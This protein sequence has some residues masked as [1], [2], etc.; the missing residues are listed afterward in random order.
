MISNRK[1][2]IV[3]VLLCLWVLL[4]AIAGAA[5]NESPMLK[6]RVLRGELPPV[7]ERLPK[8][9]VVIEP[10]SE[11]GQYGGTL[12]MALTGRHYVFQ[13]MLGG[14]ISDQ[15][16]YTW[17][18]DASEM[19]PNW[20]SETTISED[21]KVFTVYLRE[22]IKWSDGVPVTV[23][24][25]LFGYQDV[26]FNPELTPV[27]PTWLRGVEFKKIS[28]YVLE[29]HLPAPSPQFRRYFAGS[30]ITAANDT[31]IAKHYYERFH[32][33]YVD[34]NELA[35]AMK[36]EGIDTWQELFEAKVQNDNPEKPVL[37]MWKVV[38]V[39]TD[40]VIAERNPYYWKVD[41]EG[42][43]LPYI[44]RLQM[45]IVNSD[46]V[47]TMRAMAGEYDF[48]IF[49]ISL[50]DYPTLVSGE[51]RGGYRTFLWEGVEADL[52][53][54]VNQTYEEDTVIG[55]LLRKAEFKQALSYAIDR[56]EINELV[57]MGTGK[58]I[59]LS[60]LEG[61]SI[62]KPDYPN[63]HSEYNPS[64]AK[65]LLD[66]LGLIDRDGDGWRDRPDGQMLRLDLLATSGWDSHIQ[67]GE[68]M[69]SYWDSI[70]I[71]T[72]LEVYSFERRDQLENANRF[73][74]SI[75]KISNMVYPT[76]LGTAVH[77]LFCEGSFA[78]LWT[79][80]IAT[81][82][83]QGKEPSA[84]YLAANDVFQ[85]I[86]KEIDP[87]R[88]DKLARDFWEIYYRNLWTIGVVQ[89]VPRPIVVHNRLKNVP[90]RVVNSWDPLKT[91]SNADHAMWYIAD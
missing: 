84:D 56:D 20:V 91:P 55:D 73:Q 87:G 69:K 40:R 10:Y 30:F 41:T 16:P 58:P 35:A 43:Q 45:D 63:M 88:R 66:E 8:E 44:D 65:A 27:A 54:N 7:T 32:P 38:S 13:S 33:K 52:Y 28:D 47:V 82:G 61:T 59:S 70:G 49:H 21:A 67:A 89:Q 18:R 83:E 76:N 85:E 62:Y 31:I 15:D 75:W 71:N 34:A 24:D 72:R 64:K 25:L 3:C 5:Y 68:L 11:I 74:A 29:F 17:N 81:D 19:R 23:D 79:D 36:A 90:E 4:S 42:N 9:P 2:R 50:A 14:R 37:K 22:G 78:P 60:P 6:E 86:L 48:T 12:R 1:I 53:I 39:S 51:D 57:Y 46:E 26:A 77:N 80:W